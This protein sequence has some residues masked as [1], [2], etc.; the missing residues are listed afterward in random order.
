MN[1][2]M[3]EVI[4]MLL[5]NMLEKDFDQF[6]D[7]RLMDPYEELE[8]SPYDAKLGLNMADDA[9]KVVNGTLDI[10]KF[11]EKYHASL[12]EEFGQTCNPRGI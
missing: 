3:K 5:K 2:S 11:H 7:E 8:N 6:V 10:K 1:K 12:I 4:N 9:R